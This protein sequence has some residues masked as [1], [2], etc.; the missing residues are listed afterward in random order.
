LCSEHNALV[1]DVV[2]LARAVLTS[3]VKNVS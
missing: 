1:G 2:P 3:F